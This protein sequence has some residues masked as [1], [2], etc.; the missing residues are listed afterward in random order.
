MSAAHNRRH[1]D[2]W[3]YW[4]GGTARSNRLAYPWRPVSAVRRWR[5]A[6]WSTHG[7]GPPPNLFCAV[8]Y[9]RR[10]FSP[11]PTE[12]HRR[13]IRELV[14][15]V[16]ARP[17]SAQPPRS[18]ELLHISPLS[19]AHSVHL[20]WPADALDLTVPLALG[21]ISPPA[22]TG[23]GYSV[24][25][26]RHFPPLPS[27]ARRA[28]R[29]HPTSLF[30]IPP[31]TTPPP[32]PLRGR[33]PRLF[34]PSPRRRDACAA[35]RHFKHNHKPRSAPYLVQRRLNNNLGAFGQAF[36]FC[37]PRSPACVTHHPHRLCRSARACSTHRVT[38]ET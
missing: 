34:S 38:S 26:A 13:R 6:R 30:N 10:L 28:V 24:P 23:P 18:T 36:R 29:T 1:I 9:R 31:P 5:I 27:Q 21:Q 12:H 15:S 22:A 7:Q 16:P 14:S 8:R 2:L 17:A 33:A 37:F 11:T 20:A 25:I 32:P 35:G 3:H 4:N 19:R